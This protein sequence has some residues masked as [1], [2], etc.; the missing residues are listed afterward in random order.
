MKT[1]SRRKEILSSAVSKIR[2]NLEADKKIYDEAVKLE[3]EI[4]ANVKAK[5]YLKNDILKNL[6]FTHYEEQ[7][8]LIILESN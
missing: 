1:L 7:K 8:G 6:Y 3:K 4:D 5:K 2:S